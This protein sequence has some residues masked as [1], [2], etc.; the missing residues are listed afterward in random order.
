MKNKQNDQAV[1]NSDENLD[2][3]TADEIIEQLVEQLEVITDK[4]QRALADYQN[5]VR[6]TRK[7]KTKITKL[8]AKNFVED[9]L[10]PLSHLAMASEQLNDTGLSMVVEQLWVSL[11]SNGLQKIDAMGKDFDIETMEVTDKG[12]KSKKVIKIV[13][14]GYRLNGEVIRHAKVILD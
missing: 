14:D 13:S 2:E 4:E 10:Q 5:L 6:R 1:K 11:E 8:A 12:E 7:D 3:F 9:L